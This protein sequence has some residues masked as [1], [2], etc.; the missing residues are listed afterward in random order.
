MA[1]DFKRKR[2]AMTSQTPR[3]ATKLPDNA[4]Q[5][6]EEYSAMFK[7][8]NGWGAGISN[9]AFL[10]GVEWQRKRAQKLVEELREYADARCLLDFDRAVEDFKRGE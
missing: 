10:A 9:E 1:A 3:E 6:A 8:D 4:R 5:A 7:P 2:S